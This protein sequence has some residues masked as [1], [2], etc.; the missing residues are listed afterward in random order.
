MS[1]SVDAYFIVDPSVLVIFNND[2]TFK[3]VPPVSSET[4]GG[5]A[6]PCTTLPIFT[7]LLIKYA[8]LLH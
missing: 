5:Q 1:I 7:P 8:D 4:G 2:L 6:G 3:N